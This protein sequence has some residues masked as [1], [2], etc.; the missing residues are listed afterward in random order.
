MKNLFVGVLVFLLPQLCVADIQFFSEFE[1]LSHTPSQPIQDFES[2]WSSPYRE[3]DSALQYVQFA[4]GLQFENWRIAYVYQEFG[5]LRYVPDSGK[6]YW[7]SENN[8]PLEINREY[9]VDID[10]FYYRAQGLRISFLQAF[11]N[12]W[13]TKIGLELLQGNSLLAGSLKGQV[14]PL[15]DSDYD[16]NDIN[17]DYYYSNDFLFEREVKTPTG[18][19][20]S[21]DWSLSWRQDR[22]TN[23]SVDIKNLYGLIN[24]NDAPHTVARVSSDN[25]EYDANGYVIVHATLQGKH[26]FHDYRQQLPLIVKFK[27]FLQFGSQQS[28]L[29]EYFYTDLVKISSFGMVYFSDSSTQ[30]EIVYKPNVRALGLNINNKWLGFNFAS[31]EID[32]SKSRFIAFGLQLRI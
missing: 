22:K 23:M 20:L 29:F 27:S 18:N 24:W 28:L 8:L 12:N 31:D 3:A 10:A 19:G 7:L 6:F 25:K 16:F 11:N 26:A 9:E 5:N 1:Y 13:L 14:T 17:I 15:S 30:V 2:N 4:V 32:I 21:V